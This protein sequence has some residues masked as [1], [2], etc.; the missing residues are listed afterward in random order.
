MRNESIKNKKKFSIRKTQIK[1][2]TTIK[3]ER[4]KEKLAKHQRE[5]VEKD[6]RGGVK[7]KKK[8]VKNERRELQ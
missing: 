1:K 2:I 7:K 5:I 6:G 4:E 3:N 8:K